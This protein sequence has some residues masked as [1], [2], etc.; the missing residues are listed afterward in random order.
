MAK[1]AVKKTKKLNDLGSFFCSECGLVVTVDEECVCAEP[2]DIVCC[3]RQM[4]P[5]K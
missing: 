4:Q 5:K 3:G 1:K 2:C